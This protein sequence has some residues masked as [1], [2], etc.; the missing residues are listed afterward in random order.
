MIQTFRTAAFVY[1]AFIALGCLPGTNVNAQ[2]SDPINV[3]VVVM[4]GEDAKENGFLTGWDVQNAF[5][6]AGSN[7]L[8]L[9]RIRVDTKSA[10][11]KTAGPF[12][13]ASYPE[14]WSE[15]QITEFKDE[16]SRKAL[17]FG[18]G[19]GHFE[20]QG[21]TLKVDPFQGQSSDPFDSGPRGLMWLRMGIESSADLEAGAAKMLAI[22][23][24][25]DQGLPRI[26]LFSLRSVPGFDPF[27]APPA[28]GH[29]SMDP[30]TPLRARQPR[31]TTAAA[32]PFA[33]SG[34]GTDPFGG[35]GNASNLPAAADPF[36]DVDESR[37]QDPNWMPPAEKLDIDDSIARSQQQLEKLKGQLK[38]LHHQYTA[39]ST[40]AEREKIRQQGQQVILEFS[41]MQN[42]LQKARIASLSLQLEKLK[43]SVGNSKPQKEKVERMLQQI[44]PVKE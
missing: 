20:S 41:R 21:K 1:L 18:I 15:K 31:A 25:F 42:Q 17:L 39:S 29:R 44:F 27:S 7:Y 32:D 12:F 28:I 3:E 36:A 26:D 43:A 33:D 24:A 19:E 6:S 40:D 30:K 38:T 4:L 10:L 14:A 23:K 8:A 2:V 13:A 22:A 35:P 16:C 11:P 34:N 9:N 37:Q 5:R